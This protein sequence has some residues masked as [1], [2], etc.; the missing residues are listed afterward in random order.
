M[1]NSYTIQSPDGVFLVTTRGKFLIIY[2]F[3]DAVQ[4]LNDLHWGGVTQGCCVGPALPRLQI[5]PSVV[6]IPSSWEQEK[7]SP[8][9][10]ILW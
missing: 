8:G 10:K 7:C 6:E 4:S 9:G 3:L 2:T 1:G 5:S